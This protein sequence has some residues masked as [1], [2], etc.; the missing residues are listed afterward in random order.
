[1]PSLSVEALLVS[2]HRQLKKFYQFSRGRIPLAFVVCVQAFI[3]FDLFS[4]R[5]NRLKFT[6]YY[7]YMNGIVIGKS[8]VCRYKVSKDRIA[9]SHLSIFV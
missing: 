4:Q 8:T 9:Y 5:A 2:R 3:V 6:V 7:K 1:V